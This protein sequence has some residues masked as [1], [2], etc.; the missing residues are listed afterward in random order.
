[1]NNFFPDFRL[2]LFKFPDYKGFRGG[3]PNPAGLARGACKPVATNMPPL[4]GLVG[5]PPNPL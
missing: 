1:M 3:L 5:P 2:N 4:Q